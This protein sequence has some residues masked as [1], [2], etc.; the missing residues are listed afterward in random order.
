MMAATSQN[1]SQYAR[2]YVDYKSTSPPASFP[3]PMSTPQ[4]G[5]DPHLN[6]CRVATAKACAV[7]GF[8]RW[9]IQNVDGNPKYSDYRSVEHGT[10]QYLPGAGLRQPQKRDFIEPEYF[11]D[12][13]APY[14]LS[15]NQCPHGETTGISPSEKV[16]FDNMFTS[17]DMDIGNRGSRSCMG[18]KKDT[19]NSY[20]GWDTNANGVPIWEAN[21]EMMPGCSS[22]HNHGAH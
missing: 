20:S 4:P 21:A 7:Q 15:K 14:C 9:E 12:C 13:T 17:W 2:T 16:L 5:N 18:I 3:P 8:N 10:V 6:T 22:T 1:P 11:Y 19:Y